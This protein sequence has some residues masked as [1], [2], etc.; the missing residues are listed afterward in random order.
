MLANSNANKKGRKTVKKVGKA[1]QQD[2]EL[3]ISDANLALK[4][5]GKVSISVYRLNQ[6][7]SPRFRLAVSFGWLTLAGC[8]LDGL[9][10]AG[11]LAWWLEQW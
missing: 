7:R 2:L 11:R 6:P 3:S 9:T 5:R 4:F 10:L 1:M 8:A